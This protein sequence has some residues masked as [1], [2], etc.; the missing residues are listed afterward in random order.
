M[1]LP[2][3]Q[4]WKK[5]VPGSLRCS[6]PRQQV[7]KGN[8]NKVKGKQRKLVQQE[9]KLTAKGYW[10]LCTSARVAWCYRAYWPVI[11]SL[12]ILSRLLK[13]QRPYIQYAFEKVLFTNKSQDIIKQ[14]VRFNFDGN[15]DDDESDCINADDKNDDDQDAHSSIDGDAED[16]DE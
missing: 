8:K 7:K 16:S 12:W 2:T 5:N 6:I 14:Y 3:L 1:T 10:N 4:N 9:W 15:H 11:S 13:T